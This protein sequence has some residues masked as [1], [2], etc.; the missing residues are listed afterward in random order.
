M[1]IQEDKV[2]IQKLALVD[3]PHKVSADIFDMKT[4]QIKLG[5]KR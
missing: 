4:H 5:Y 3:R 1:P 2:K